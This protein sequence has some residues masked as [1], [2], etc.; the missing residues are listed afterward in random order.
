MSESSNF[1]RLIQLL[2]KGG[3]MVL[4]QVLEKCTAPLTASDYI[5]QNQGNVLKLKFTE[6]QRQRVVGLEMDKMDITLLCRLIFDLFNNSL[7]EKERKYI[8]NIKMERDSMMHSEFLESAKVN[9]QLF[10]RRWQ[11]ISAALRNIAEEL[12][13]PFKREL[14]D[15]IENTKKSDPE[16]NEIIKTLKEWCQSNTDLQEKVDALADS[17]NDLKGILFVMEAQIIKI[18]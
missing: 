3:T 10:E 8:K 12:L 17:V 9:T 16:L 4:R 5:Y 18:S 2:A 11:D 6:K 14:E 1:N 15:F 7:T 13:P